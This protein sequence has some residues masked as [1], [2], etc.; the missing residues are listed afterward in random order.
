MKTKTSYLFGE[1]TSYKQG[2]KK[3]KGSESI[4]ELFS[5]YY[6]QLDLLKYK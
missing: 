4:F 2:L 3:F 5:Q 1:K 6:L